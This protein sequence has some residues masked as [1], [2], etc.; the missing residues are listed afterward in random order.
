MSHFTEVK[1]RI[2]DIE[3]LRFAC[4]E[5]G[6]TLLQN[7][8]SRGC[9][10]NTTKGDYVVQLKGPYDIALNKQ[11]DGTFGLTA[12]LWQGHVDKEPERCLRNESAEEGRMMH[13]QVQLLERPTH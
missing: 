2:K 3:A 4:Q 6:L 12:D 1:T 9:Y 13:P 5:L 8:D 10:E 11:P 7:A